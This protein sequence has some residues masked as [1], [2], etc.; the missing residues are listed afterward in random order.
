VGSVN[1]GLR[2]AVPETDR[3]LVVYQDLISGQTDLGTLERYLGNSLDRSALENVVGSGKDRNAKREIT[4]FERML[5]RRGQLAGARAATR[6]SP[7]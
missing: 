7:D 4:A 3:F 6:A 5:L 1:I 2:S